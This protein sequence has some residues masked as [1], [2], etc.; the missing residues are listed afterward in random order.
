[1]FRPLTRREG[2]QT[3]HWTGASTGTLDGLDVVGKR[4]PD[5]T[6]NEE[7]ECHD[8]DNDDNNNNNNINPLQTSEAI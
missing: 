7:D 1:M 6:G 3:I 4:I 8:D 2:A 5:P